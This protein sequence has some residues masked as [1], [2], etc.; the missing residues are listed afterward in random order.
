MKSKKSGSKG[1]AKVKIAKLKL[2]KDSIENLSN[3]DAA[4]VKGGRPK[5]SIEQR[6][7]Y[8]C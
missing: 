5:T 7:W 4:T 1:K 3:R 6:S 8:A 2:H